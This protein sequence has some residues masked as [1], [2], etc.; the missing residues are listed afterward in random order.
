MPAHVILTEKIEPFQ[1]AALQRIAEIIAE[2]LSGSE[3]RD[4]F[5]RSGFSHITFIN[6]AK[7]R[8]IHIALEQIQNE[9]GGQR[10]VIEIIEKF[11]DGQEFLVKSEK[12]EP[13]IIKINEVLNF[14]KLKYDMKSS[15]VTFN[16]RIKQF[17]HENDNSQER[18]KALYVGGGIL[19]ILK[20]SEKELNYE[21]LK[22]CFPKAPKKSFDGGLFLLQEYLLLKTNNDGICILTQKANDILSD[23]IDLNTRILKLLQVNPFDLNEISALLR[24]NFDTI[25]AVFINLSNERLV[26]STSYSSGGTP[27]AQLTPNGTKFLKENSDE[28]PKFTIGTAG[29]VYVGNNINVTNIQGTIDQLIVQI[30]AAKDID[31][32]TKKELKTKLEKLKYAA[33]ETLEFA[34]SVGGQFAVESLLKSFFT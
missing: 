20:I 16:S 10:K 28:S 12:R 34:K 31:D 33:R 21:L 32:K 7:R 26:T 4:F 13:T 18:L 24:T 3:I 25:V 5:N 27:V 22:E 1:P 14:Y 6:D 8:F 19:R 17:S 29:T 23:D 9:V 2:N 15:T 30:D 11:C